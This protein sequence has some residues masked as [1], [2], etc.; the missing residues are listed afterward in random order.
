M[1]KFV[2]KCYVVL[3]VNAIGI[4]SERFVVYILFYKIWRCQKYTNLSSL[5]WILVT[6]LGRGSS[7]YSV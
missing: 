5:C 6:S 2:S 3:F 7:N 4:L 1:I